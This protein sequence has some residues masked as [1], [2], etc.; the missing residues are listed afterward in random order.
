MQGTCDAGGRPPVP[1]PGPVPRCLAVNSRE[2]PGRRTAG[3][4]VGLCIRTSSRESR[5]QAAGQQLAQTHAWLPTQPA[6]PLCRPWVVHSKQSCMPRSRSRRSV[7]P[8]PLRQGGRVSPA[9]CRR[10]HVPAPP[11]LLNPFPLYRR[12]AASTPGLRSSSR[13]LCSSRYSA[14]RARTPGCAHASHLSQTAL[15]RT[16]CML[17]LACQLSV[18]PSAPQMLP[19]H[20]Y[21]A[22][23]LLC[24]CRRK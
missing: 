10:E 14:T 13:T 11:A 19:A 7:N 5:C 15:V 2:R 24:T 21:S 23:S 6:A 20:I 17:Q 16:H 1:V 3:L 12:S 9:I 18:C 22:C 4:I 8:W